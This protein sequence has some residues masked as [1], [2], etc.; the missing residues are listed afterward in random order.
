M[1][2]SGPESHPPGQE[3]EPAPLDFYSAGHSYFSAGQE[4]DSPYQ[5]LDLDSLDEDLYAATPDAVMETSLCMLESSEPQDPTAAEQVEL[6]SELTKLEAEILTLRGVLAAKER[7]CGELKKKLGQVASVGLRQNLSKSWH[8][9][10]VSNAYMK[11]KTSTALSTVGT[12]ICR[13]FE[14]MRKSSTFRSFEGLMG[15]I[16]SRV[17]GGREFDSDCLPSPGRGSDPFSVPGSGDH[18]APQLGDQQLSVL[19]P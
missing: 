6:R 19:E 3:S 13:K 9:V 11:Q 17:G 14:D 8:D 12:A 10:Q 2:L 5:E 7:R 1:A 15:T 4:L 18:P 16:K